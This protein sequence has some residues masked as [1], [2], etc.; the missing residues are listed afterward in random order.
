MKTT[1]NKDSHY[2]CQMETFDVI[3]PFGFG[4]TSGKKSWTECVVSEHRY[5]LEDNYKIS[6]V[7]IDPRFAGRDFYICDF[8]SLLE[9]GLILEKTNENQHIE[10]V[11]WT[12]ELTPTVYVEH[13]GYVVV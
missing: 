8:E 7:P 2:F 6:L 9:D 13:S 12:E 5:R 1:I 3:T 4:I 10:F 11:S